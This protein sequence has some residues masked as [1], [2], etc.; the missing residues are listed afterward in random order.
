M[1]D[2]ARGR[3]TST[4]RFRDVLAFGP[5]H[6]MAEGMWEVKR[7]DRDPELPDYTA[8]CDACDEAELPDFGPFDF[9]VPP[10]CEAAAKAVLENCDDNRHHEKR[11]DDP[12]FDFVLL[13]EDWEWVEG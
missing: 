12:G 6:S 13:P 1:A 9:E 3:A 5:F 10:G 8:L 4:I 2:G 7:D 11:E